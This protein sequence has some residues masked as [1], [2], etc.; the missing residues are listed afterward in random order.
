M[1]IGVNFLVRIETLYLLQRQS[2]GLLGAQEDSKYLA[3]C[4]LNKGSAVHWNNSSYYSE[5]FQ[6]YKKRS[7]RILFAS[8]GK[9]KGRKKCLI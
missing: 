6:S 7:D 3:V 2:S 1:F 8:R 5:L 4:I 9:K